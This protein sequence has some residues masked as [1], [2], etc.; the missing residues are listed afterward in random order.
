MYYGQVY[1][2]YGRPDKHI[3]TIEVESI[4]SGARVRIEAA[5]ELGNA[6]YQVYA[7]N[8]FAGSTWCPEGVK[9]E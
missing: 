1:G 3:K 6:Y 9:S 2:A 5:P 4:S 8:I 7:N